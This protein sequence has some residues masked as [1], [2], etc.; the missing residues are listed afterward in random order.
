M[1]TLKLSHCD[2]LLGLP[3]LVIKH[4]G[5]KTEVKVT[6]TCAYQGKLC[7]LCGDLS[8]LQ[9]SGLVGPQ[10]CSYSK[11][12]LLTASYRVS[13]SSQS[14]RSPLPSKI[15]SQ[16]EKE[17]SECLKVKE[18][19]TVDIFNSFRGQVGPCS[20]HSHQVV[21][22]TTRVCFSRRPVVACSPLCKA[23][24]GSNVDKSVEFTCMPR[25]RVAE[26]YAE[27]IR[28]GIVIPELE[29]MPVTFSSQL[30]VPRSC[31]PVVN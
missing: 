1:I 9:L 19:P 13:L 25:G 7:G 24:S 15:E 17:N 26:R 12:E 10:Q 23:A 22:E 18:L 5:R 27:K 6:P 30:T 11:P 31:V 20:R 14:C 28:R 2:M 8:G 3:A 29:A 16:L 4:D 21:E